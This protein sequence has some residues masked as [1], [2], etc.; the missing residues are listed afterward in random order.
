MKSKSVLS[1]DMRLGKDTSHDEW[2]DNF[3][4]NRTPFVMQS[5]LQKDH[6]SFWSIFLFLVLFLGTDD[7]QLV[8]LGLGDEGGGPHH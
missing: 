5:L 1:G 7:V 6:W 4:R 8:Q 3:T 2:G